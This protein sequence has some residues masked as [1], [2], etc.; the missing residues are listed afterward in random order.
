M[1][2]YSYIPVVLVAVSVHRLSVEM[3]TVIL[4]IEKKNSH[5]YEII[6]YMRRYTVRLLE[7]AIIWCLHRTSVTYKWQCVCKASVQ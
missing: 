5:T 7:I 1:S 3:F 6:P 2:T 4:Q